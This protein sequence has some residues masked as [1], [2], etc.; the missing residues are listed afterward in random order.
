MASRIGCRITGKNQGSLEFS[1]VEEA[2][3][4][5]SMDLG[6]IKEVRGSSM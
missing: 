4:G 3:F 5:K 2:Q 6:G 1:L